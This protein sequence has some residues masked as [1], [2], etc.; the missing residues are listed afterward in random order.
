MS[1]EEAA[2]LKVPHKLL[3]VLRQQLE[4]GISTVLL[5][6]GNSMA[7]TEAPAITAAARTQAPSAGAQ[8]VVEEALVAS[9]SDVP[10]FGMSEEDIMA[11]RLPIR[12]GM[13]KY[14]SS[15]KVSRLEAAVPYGCSRKWGSAAQITKRKRGGEYA[16]KVLGML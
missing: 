13:F 10:S 1:Q 9:M 2:S 5:P 12:T 16:L 3:A 15:V 4:L 11:R 7:E 14:G 8:L 6:T